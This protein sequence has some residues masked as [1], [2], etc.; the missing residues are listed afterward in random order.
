[1]TA[2]QNIETALTRVRKH[3]GPTART[4]LTASAG[5]SLW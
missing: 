2:E 4:A 1:M 5:L 3:P